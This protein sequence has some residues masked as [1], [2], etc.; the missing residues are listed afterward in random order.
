MAIVETGPLMY[1]GVIEETGNR[2]G[3]RL[4]PATA[5]TCASV[6]I[7]IVTGDGG[8]YTRMHAK[9]AREYAAALLRLADAA[10]AMNEMRP[11]YLSDVARLE[12]R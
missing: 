10:D 7:A 3:A 9:E 4:A 2:V 5:W 12:R 1:E 8:G 11:S 6:S